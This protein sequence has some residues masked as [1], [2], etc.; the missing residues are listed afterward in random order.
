MERR[1]TSHTE[2]EEM[3]QRRR[4]LGQARKGDEKAIGKLFE[5]YQVKVYTGETLKKSKTSFSK[6]PQPLSSEKRQGSK[7]KKPSAAKPPKSTT[8]KPAAEKASSQPTPKVSS[9][10]AKP[11][12]QTKTANVKKVLTKSKPTK[13]APKSPKSSPKSAKPAKT[14]KPK[15]STKVVKGSKAKTSSAKGKKTGKK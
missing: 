15:A 4:L 1:V 2:E 10:S 6:D 14:A 8:K 13:S 12:A 9:Q 3:N 5:L 11:K 7:V